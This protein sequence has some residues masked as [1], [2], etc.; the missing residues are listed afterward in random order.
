MVVK[1]RPSNIAST[2]QAKPRLYDFFIDPL[3]HFCTRRPMLTGLMI[4][5]N[6]TEQNLSSKSRLVRKRGMTKVQLAGTMVG[7]AGG[8]AAAPAG[9]LLMAVSWC[10]SNEGARRW[11]STAGSM[12]LCLT[13][14]LII[15]GAYC[16]DWL[17]KKWTRRPLKPVR[18]H[19]EDKQRL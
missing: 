14:P 13:I 17:E 12:L 19:N 15:L 5:P 11:L 1:Q 4:D 9:S 3:R 18:Y 10:T 16:M 8:V 6:A 2:S 7:L